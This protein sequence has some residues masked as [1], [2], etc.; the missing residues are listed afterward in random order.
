[1]N[2]TIQVHNCGTS[3]RIT[4]KTVAWLY[5]K[6]DGT[7]YVK[8]EYPI[9]EEWIQKYRV[10]RN[11]GKPLDA[12]RFAYALWRFQNDICSTECLQAE[13]KKRYACCDKAELM[14]CVCMYSYRCPVHGETHIGTHD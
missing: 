11:C 8:D 9:T 10:C 14:P 1:M 13:T 3:I 4:D 6:R 5:P 12:E 2:E 7:L